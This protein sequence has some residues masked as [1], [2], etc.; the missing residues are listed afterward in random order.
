MALLKE[1]RVIKPI[2]SDIL[3]GV[4]A[5]PDS[6]ALAHLL[7][8]YG[9]KLALKEKITLLHVNHGWRGEASD[10]DQT[11]VEALAQSWGVESFSVRVPAE[12]IPK[13]RSPEDYAREL[14]RAVYKKWIQ[15]KKRLGSL[16]PIVVTA[17]H[18]DDL[19]ETVLWRILTGSGATHGG[20]VLFQSEI[21]MRPFL[22]VRK[23]EIFRYLAQEKLKWREDASNKDPKFL[24]NRM[25]LELIPTLSALFP[26][27]ISH[28]ID[29][30]IRAQTNVLHQTPS[31][32]LG[33]LDSPVLDL[34]PMLGIR[35]RKNNWIEV[36]KLNQKND[37]TGCVSLPG[38]WRLSKETKK[39]GDR[40]VLE[41]K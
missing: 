33:D 19:A 15:E 21:E 26:K 16:N 37:A 41:R 6:V 2:G 5:G 23:D 4:S 17:H 34:M 9:R 28:L 39:G 27:A 8:H 31:P 40:W 30:G 29:A 11:F 13:G 20:G 12:K 36:S 22:R 1:F 25:R 10:Q 35:V 18:G 7:V 38:G 14:R 24:R 3:I 32:F